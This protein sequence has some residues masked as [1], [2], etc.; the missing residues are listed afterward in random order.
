[1]LIVVALLMAG[2]LLGS[3]ALALG[4]DRVVD[5]DSLRG[6]DALLG[7]NVGHVDG[8]EGGGGCI[9]P[10]AASWSGAAGVALAPLTL[11]PLFGRTR[12]A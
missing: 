7:D 6:L 10:T 2:M 1:V 8:P 4:D 5:C 12:R 3:I 9:V 11:W